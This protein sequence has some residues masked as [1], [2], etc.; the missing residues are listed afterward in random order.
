M[1]MKYDS[2][3]LINLI[4]IHYVVPVFTC[5]KGIL[6]FA[7][8]WERCPKKRSAKWGRCP[9]KRSMLEVICHGAIWSLWLARNERIFKKRHSSASRIMDD[10]IALVFTWFKRRG[11]LRNCN[12]SLWCISPFNCL[13]GNR[14]F[15]TK[16]RGEEA[17]AGDEGAESLL[18]A[19]KMG[20]LKLR[21]Q[22]KMS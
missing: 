7:T 3:E 1:K 4:H 13:S 20:R 6:E 10:I 2:G 12:W 22:N 18:A 21:L 8:K 14:M 5:A 16:E 17:S 15:R 19:M 9:K 11:R